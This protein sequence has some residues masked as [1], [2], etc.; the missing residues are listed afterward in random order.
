MIVFAPSFGGP[1]VQVSAAGGKPKVVTGVSVVSSTIS[2]R[3]PSFL[4]DGKHFLFLHSP[5]G[6]AADQNEIHLGSLDGGDQLVLPGEI[7]R[8]AVCRRTVAGG[9]RRL[10][11][12]LEV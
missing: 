6:N 5:Y 8:R 11:A 2:D 4:P 3:W 9:A 1:L 10:A 12:R 7:L